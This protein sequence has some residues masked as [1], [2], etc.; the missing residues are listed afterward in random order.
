MARTGAVAIAA[1]PATTAPAATNG[2][3]SRPAP[4]PHPWC[5]H[6]ADASVD[7]RNIALAANR[8]TAATCP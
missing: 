7:G 2:K 5:Q 6:R 4:Q 8:P 1:A 3:A